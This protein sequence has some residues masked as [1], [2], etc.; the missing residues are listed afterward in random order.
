MNHAEII[1]IGNELLSGLTINSNASWIA[2]KLSNAGISVNWITTIADRREEIKFALRTAASRAEIILC[3]GGLG[4]TPDDITKNTICEFFQTKLVLHSPTLENVIQ[5]FKRRK[6]KMPEVNRGQAMVPESAG[7]IPNRL[8]TAPGLLFDQQDKI[9]VFMPGVPGEMKSMIDH[10]IIPLIKK[11]YKVLP[12]R[13]HLIRTTGIAESMLY[14]KL[15][16]VFEKYPDIMVSYLP[17]FTGVDIRLKVH[18]QEKSKEPDLENI[19]FKL[20]EIVGSYI[21]TEQEE[22]LQDVLAGLLTEKSLT[23]AIAESF[24]GGLISDRITDVPG[25]S[26]YFLG[27]V[28]TY[29]NKSKTEQ[30]KVAE[31][32]ISKYGAVSEQTIKEMVTG[33][34]NLF[35][36]NCA[37]A[38]TGIAGPTGATEIKPIGLCYLAAGYNDNIRIK[39]F[40]F[41]KDRR[42]NKERG[43][44]AGLEL[45]RRLVLNIE[46]N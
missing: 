17:K 43:T 1:S 29:S 21:Y 18:G 11:K 44:V 31:E 36:S 30:L 35:G 8:G 14:E 20:R 34:Q 15:H 19:S 41:G 16:P 7:I 4:P 27:S 33:V 13:T 25:S 9:F 24:T 10:D 12:F 23:L 38:S 37:I 22:E 6:I 39:E 45:L 5:I 2:Q 32:T 42:I 46:D 28:V 3:T 40:N 26:T